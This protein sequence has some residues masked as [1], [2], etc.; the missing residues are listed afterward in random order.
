MAGGTWDL[1]TFSDTVG[2]VTLT[3]GSITGT[4]GVLTGSAYAV[5]SG[6]LSVNLAGTG[7]LTKTTAGTVLLS[8]T[9][10][11]TGTT[12]ISA[13]TLQLAGGN[14][15]ADTSSV[16]LANVAGA[17]LDLGGTSETIGGLSGGGALG[18]NVTLGAGTLT[19]N[20]TA[21]A[22]YAGVVSGSGGLTKTGVSTLTLSG[23]NIYT[24]PTQVNAGTL[25]LGAANRINDASAV[26]VAAGAIF[27][28]SNFAETVGSIASA[29]S[30]VLG[31]ATL[32]S[33]GDNTS[34]AFT[35][36]ASGTGGLVK[37]GSGTLT[38]GG[39]NTYTGATTVSAGTLAVTANNAL[40]TNAAGTSVAVGAT[41]DLR[42]VAYTTTEAVILNGGTLATSTGT[43]SLAGPVTLG[44]ASSV[45]VAGT[46]LTLNGALN[47]GGFGLT[48][49]GSGNTLLNGVVSG[50]GGLTKLGAGT[51]TLAGTNTYAGATT[52]NGGTLVATRAS[53]L[54]TVGSGTTV[55]AG[56]TLELDGTL[57]YAEPVALNGATLAW[58][59]GSPTL[60][61]TLA[62]A[63]ANSIGGAAGA[64]TLGGVVS[65]T[66]GFD[67]TG[68]GTLLVTGNNTYGG[69][70]QVSGG[71]LQVSSNN[72]LGSIAAGTSV[73]ANGRLIIDGIAIGAEPVT[74]NGPGLFG[75]GAITS[76]GAASIAGPITLAADSVVA[77]NAGST[78]TLSGPVDGAFGL[79]TNGAGRLNLNGTVGGTTPLAFLTTGP[80]GTTGI[81]AGL[82][83]TSGSQS[84]GN[85]TVIAS[86]VT[87]QSTGGDLIASRAGDGCGC[88]LAFGG[89]ATSDFGN[90][91]NDFGTVGV[92]AGGDATLRDAN[93]ITLAASSVGGNLILAANGAV[94]QTGAIRVAGTSSVSAGPGP[95]T[96]NGA[97][98]F[99]GDVAVSTTGAAQVNDV[100]ALALGA[101]TIGSLVA[102]AGGSVT[103]NA[104]ITAVGGGSSI[105][106]AG[107]TFTN[108]A[109][110]AAL[111]PGAGRWIVYSADPAGNV[112]GGLASG[113]QAVWNR[114]YPGGVSEAGNR[115]V[116][117][118]QPTL[119]FTS[120]D[121][122]KTYGQDA[123]AAVAGA[124][125]VTGFVDAAAYGGVF[126]QD[127]VA[128]TFTG[129]PVVASIGAPATAAVAGS[130]YP[131]LV[132]VSAVTPTTGYGKT[133]ASTGIVTVNAAP[134]TITA[135]NQS[136]VYG[137]PDPTLTATF[138]GLQNGET[139][140]VVSG[141]SIFA[142]TGA[143]ATFVGSP[144]P[145]IP[146]GA[147]AANYTISYVDGLLTV[148][149]RP[150]AIAADPQSKVYG[151]PDPLLTYTVGGAGLAYGDVLA[152]ALT[153]IAGE[154]VAASPYAILQ[155]TLTDAANPNYAIAYTGNVLAITPA[156]LIGTV[157][158]ADKVYDTTTT[159]L[160]TGRA[161]SGV[162]SGDAVSYVGGV[163]TF[164]DRNVGNGKTVTASGLSLVGADAPN[165]TVNTTA[166]TTAAITPAT[167]TY[168]A[169]PA[170]VL[171]GTPLPMFTG[172]VQGFVG[173]DTL[174][175]A[176]SGGLAFTSPASSVS[177][178]GLYP[179]NGSGLTAD[180]G[181][182][183]FVQ[184][185]TNAT[186]LTIQP[187][188]DPPP[189][190]LPPVVIPDVYTGALASAAQSE[191]TCAQLQAGAQTE[192]LCGAQQNFRRSEQVN[193]VPGWRRVIELGTVS[194][195]IEGGGMRTP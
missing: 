16:V 45:E 135:D 100:N 54:G 73:G 155:G 50:A 156:A 48:V 55:N 120:T 176:T 29:G 184:A 7:A 165:Y 33:G 149:P 12:T 111:N 163:A 160:I 89:R 67:K 74:L 154:T 170:T 134:L 166:T 43:S 62:L 3:S 42:N 180:F 131:V 35:G 119:T 72:G 17:A 94:S 178:P 66:G 63:G 189:L 164:S 177:A 145:I 127:T 13:G 26:T 191:S 1:G 2:A 19:V 185:P 31:T 130:P 144:H 59:A 98:D 138:T 132:D 6:T 30:I 101:S 121:V 78:L 125:T 116:F 174:A 139:P 133:A 112:F 173:G 14:A 193:L 172:S 8:G 32:T 167:L 195:T 58:A 86:G 56:A 147:S 148:T 10:T 84:F 65:G 85:P 186:A 168:L 53:S 194:L 162:V 159:A 129:A 136:K 96:L 82:V 143:A 187:R 70:T 61:S 64:L 91:A 76:N 115:Y 88:A 190:P 99:G 15:I 110:A 11:R 21:A 126:T 9:N 28:L 36:V 77:P 142:P 39:A 97:N 52:V 103:V 25:Q 152:G 128:N 141:L 80:A 24:G 106:L 151:Q 83:R 69:V 57:T 49:N 161:L 5:Q 27:N 20:Q 75:T 44:A 109:G 108:N 102:T 23:A 105:V 117:S 153:R 171:R 181:N 22:A 34:T 38:L 123:T 87:L 4:S 192:T 95:I 137:N 150:I 51:L 158:A 183:V 140:S 18:G 146:S 81:N 90:A 93:A 79:T 71:T 179:I 41:L 157:T 182:Y 47:N 169:D 175:N 114:V 124:Y 92:T 60:S 113:N 104:N 118:I 188:S 40:G 37:T 46:Q 68:V 107:A 122:A